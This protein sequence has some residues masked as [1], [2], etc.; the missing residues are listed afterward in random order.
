M[1]T[2]SLSCHHAAGHNQDRGRTWCAISMLSPGSDAPRH[3][4]SNRDTGA[5][6]SQPEGEFART[7]GRIRAH[8][9]KETSAF[10]ACAPPHFRCTT[11]APCSSYSTF[12]TH[13]SRKVERADRTEPPSQAEY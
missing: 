12:V 6:R 2:L 7:L 4:R 3:I 11:E 9:H 1:R 8:Q 10:C 13:I 5:E